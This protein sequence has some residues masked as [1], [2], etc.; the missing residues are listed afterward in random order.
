M[1]RHIEG[2]AMSYHTFISG[3][4][5]GDVNYNLGFALI[6]MT[7]KAHCRVIPRWDEIV[8]KGITK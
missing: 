2:L 1:Y 4:P 8:S 3:Y 7:I 6:P 5:K